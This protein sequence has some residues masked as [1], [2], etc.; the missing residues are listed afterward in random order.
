MLISIITV[1]YNSSKTIEETFE[2]VLNQSYQNYEYIVVDG[3][4]TDNTVDIIKKYEA[5]FNGKLKYISEKDNGIY[6]AM[7][8]GLS[9]AKGDIIGIINS[10]DWYEK[11]AFEVVSQ[12]YDGSK[13]QVLYG[14]LRMM[15]NGNELKV[16][17][18]NH[19]FLISSM[20][21]HPTCFVTKK[22]YE[23]FGKFDLKY[24]AAA[25]YDLMLRYY[26]SKKVTFK[27]IYKILA[28]FALG[29]ISDTRIGV[30]EMA[31]IKYKNKLISKKKYKLILLKN[32]I[33]EK[34]FGKKKQ[35][36]L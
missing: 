32:F 24:R 20:I 34:V 3:G 21:T 36:N 12:S 27:P 13:Y 26:L 30:N 9:M 18:N 35:G 19:E 16:Y 23:D 28:N 8:K 22:T 17:L 6:D 5:S 31:E 10:D 4:S 29:G 11:D 25:D 7:N 2:S 15:K 33:M 14:F 1:C